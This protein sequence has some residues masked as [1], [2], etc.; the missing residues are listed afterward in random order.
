M[1]RREKKENEGKRQSVFNDQ[2]YVPTGNVNSLRMNTIN[3]GNTGKIKQQ[4]R[5]Q[6]YVNIIKESKRSGCLVGKTG[7]IEC[8]R[9]RSALREH[10]NRQCKFGE[11]DRL[12]YCKIALNYSL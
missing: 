6:P 7:S 4:T 12:Q 10:Y 2:N 1:A 5:Q 3:P 11:G 9:I 8:R